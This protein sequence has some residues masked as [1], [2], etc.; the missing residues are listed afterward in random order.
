MTPDR[1]ILGVEEVAG[2]Q[3]DLTAAAAIVAVG[4]GIG[5]ADKMGIIR[6]RRLR[7][8]APRS[9]PAAR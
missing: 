6:P 2:E 3:V 7:R 5:D 8:S 1:E 9:A 4:R